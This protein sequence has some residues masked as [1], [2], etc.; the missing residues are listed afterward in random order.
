MYR[1]IRVSRLSPKPCTA[2]VQ[3]C[4]NVLFTYYT[5]MVEKLQKTLLTVQ[6]R[7]SLWPRPPCFLPWAEV[8]EQ[9]S[10]ELHHSVCAGPVEGGRGGGGLVTEHMLRK[11]LFTL[12]GI[13]ELAECLVSVWLT[14]TRGL[15][16]T[17]KPTHLY[18]HIQLLTEGCA[19]SPLACDVEYRFTYSPSPSTPS[20]FA[21]SLC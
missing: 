3:A 16:L 8:C 12:S 5:S 21:H 11:A 19:L 15:V 17:W 20:S 10:H 4:N 7:T 14:A 1:M 13:R 18:T 6:T 2:S 9:W